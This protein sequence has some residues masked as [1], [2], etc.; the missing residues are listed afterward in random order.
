MCKLFNEEPFFP[1]YH[2]SKKKE[3]GVCVCAAKQKLMDMTVPLYSLNEIF[4]E[5]IEASNWAV[6]P[7]ICREWQ[8]EEWEKTFYW[9]LR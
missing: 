3:R 5:A 8:Q 4:V 6:V 7:R 9:I 1:A 2:M